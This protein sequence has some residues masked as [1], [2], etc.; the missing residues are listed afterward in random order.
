MRLP[1]RYNLR[2]LAVRRAMTLMTAG[3]IALVVAVLVLTLA[4]AHGFQ[5][6]LVATGRPDNA[7]VT[8]GGTQSEM[9]SWLTRDMARVI[10]AD[11]AVARG[12]DGN[13]LAIGEVIV[14]VNVVRRGEPTASSNVSV[15]G[16]G[17]G[18]LALRPDVRLVEGRM[19]RLGT[20]EIVVGRRL[21]QRF[22]GCRL[23]ESL[24]M[25]GRDWRVVGVLDAGGTGFDSEIWGDG[26]ICMPAF[27][28]RAYS[29]LTLR[30]ADPSRFD[31]LKRRLEADPRLPV[32]VARESDYY[33][34][35]SAQL[36]DLIRALG[37]FLVAIM[38]AGAVFG[39]LNTMYAAV[40]SRTREIATLLALGFTPRAILVSFL[41][42]SVFLCL[43]GGVLGCLLALPVHGV[44]TGT[45]N[46]S[47][48]SEVAFE[49]RL[50]PGILATGLASAALLGLI[51]GWFPARAA[52]R[53]TVS[54]ALR[55]G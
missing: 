51:G 43:I 16:V 37:V 6:T 8:R 50:T 44:S 40:G 20:N 48:F 13:P 53:R 3:G 28:R 36:A 25:G 23:G 32:Q 35:Q 15:R 29:S 54:E 24:R 17:P 42:E 2:N 19:F 49:F 18:A 14:L 45:T 9:M 12:P 27:D 10:E 1:L 46:W 30:L 33:R 22:V 52:A 26:E 7:L 4:L 38:A 31:E 39:A 34:A 55:E 11:P 41:I 5:A 21:G 47:S